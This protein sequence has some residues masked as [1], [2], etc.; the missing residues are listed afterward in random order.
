M[1]VTCLKQSA[2]TTEQSLMSKQ[3][4]FTLGRMPIKAVFIQERLNQTVVAGINPDSAQ[5][6]GNIRRRKGIQDTCF[7]RPSHGSRL[8]RVSI[9]LK[10]LYTKESRHVH[11]HSSLSPIP[12]YT[13]TSPPNTFSTIS[14]RP[15]PE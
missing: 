7:G 15:R 5:R 12:Y 2:S 9:L 8:N 1:A 13:Q 10:S 4:K 14:S 3:D 6:G 11:T